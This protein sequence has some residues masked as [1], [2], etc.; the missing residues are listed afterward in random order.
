MAPTANRGALGAELRALLSLAMPLAILQLANSGVGAVGTAYA[1]RVS[2]ATQAAVGLGMALFFGVSVIGLGLVLGFDPMVAQAVGAGEK[3][4]RSLVWQAVWMAVL[5]GV[6]LAAIQ[7]LAAW[8]MPYVGLDAETATL[9]RDY[10]LTRVPSLFPFLIGAALRTY[11]Q[12]ENRTQPLLVA[13]VVANVVN[14]PLCHLAVIELGWGAIGAGL[15]A[16]AAT[17]AMMGVELA[18]V[19]R[20]LRERGAPEV[21]ERRPDRVVL[22]RAARLGFP[23]AM[24][25]FAEVGAF[26]L[27]TVLIGYLGSRPLAA[28]NVA[29]QL[30]SLTFQIALA[31]GA[32]ASVR[33][34]LAIG[35]EDVEGTRRAGMLAIGTGVFFSLVAATA[36]FLV[37]SQL[38]GILTDEAG[39]IAA[40]VPLLA[41]ASAFQLGDGMQ[42]IAA[43]ALRGAGDT[44]VTML[45]NLAGHYLIGLPL[46][47]V[48]AFWWDRGAVGFW[49]GLSA[50]LTSVAALLTWRFWRLSARAIARV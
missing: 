49:W 13:A 15:A 43:G 16:T 25:L 4:A 27:A 6:P 32:A 11:L 37:P 2:E 24:Q 26:M 10:L 23:L 17:F 3:R 46:G 14:V 28:H 5:T 41:V 44:R 7:A 50:G 33:V 1:G 34:G 19:L 39:V 40:A 45:A 38:A 35:R 22:V 42:A 48:L 20:L 36:F 12:A 21:G 18:A 31:L 9:T 30:A 8:V 29:L 47:L